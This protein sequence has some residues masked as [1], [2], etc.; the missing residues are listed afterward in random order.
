MNE[1]YFARRSLLLSL[2]ALGVGPILTSRITRIAISLKAGSITVYFR[3][4]AMA[5]Q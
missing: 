1:L 2:G 3:F 4:A 5:F